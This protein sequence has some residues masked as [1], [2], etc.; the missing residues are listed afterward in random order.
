MFLRRG[1][2]L[3]KSRS[4]PV[5]LT[6]KAYKSEYTYEMPE[7]LKNSF[8]LANASFFNNTNWFVHRAYEVIF[9]DLVEEVKAREP[10]YDTVK[11][12]EKVLNLIKVLEPCN[13]VI[14]V[15]LPVDRD[16]G[17][18]SVV[19]AFRVQ[20]GKYRVR[21]PCLGGIYSTKRKTN[22]T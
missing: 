9:G 5:L 7:V 19:R 17:D 1:T 8:F 13:A 22:S 21:V 2:L 15:R 14:D 20:H 18:Y 12:V 3:L 6:R 10:S 4:F 11:A 16:N